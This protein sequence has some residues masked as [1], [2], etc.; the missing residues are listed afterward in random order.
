MASSA[1]DPEGE[2]RV[3]PIYTWMGRRSFLEEDVSAGYRSGDGWNGMVY[4]SV[5]G[6]DVQRA[7]G[8]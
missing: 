4:E 2:L 5:Y 8:R 3:G 7:G 6:V 1:A